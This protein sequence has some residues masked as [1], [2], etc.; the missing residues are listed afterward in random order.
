MVLIQVLLTL[1]RA[2]VAR[3]YAMDMG[4]R[5]DGKASGQTAGQRQ[6]DG[7][8]QQTIQVAG[9]ERAILGKHHLFSF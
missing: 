9:A 4:V 1:G 6:D 5:L 3:F 8:D 7:S 2:V